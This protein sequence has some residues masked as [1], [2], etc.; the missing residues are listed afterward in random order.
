MYSFERI[1]YSIRGSYLV[2]DKKGKNTLKMD[3]IHGHG[4]DIFNGVLTRWTGATMS[5]STWA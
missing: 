2:W 1:P 5:C 3:M 4:Q